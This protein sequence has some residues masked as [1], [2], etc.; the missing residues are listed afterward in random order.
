MLIC[1]L[2]P[3]METKIWYLT[4]NVR[5][6]NH[7]RYQDWFHSQVRILSSRQAPYPVPPS[8]MSFLLQYLVSP[9]AQSLRCDLIRFIV[10]VIHPSNHVLGSDVMPRWA[11]IGWLLT[12]C[13]STTISCNGKLALLYDWLFF[14][15]EKDNIMNIGKFV[16]LS[17]YD[18][19]YFR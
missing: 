1:R 8:K 18:D 16:A 13:T 17:S 2:T 10:C 7:K 4:N 14:D 15:S 5:F 6:G 9:E 12:T 19:K 11:V 3:D